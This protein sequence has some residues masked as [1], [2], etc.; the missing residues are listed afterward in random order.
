MLPNE[1]GRSLGWR[2]LAWETRTT[3]KFSDISITSTN[4]KEFF[5][6]L[7]L[8]SL[9]GEIHAH[10]TTIIAIFMLSIG[11]VSAD[12]KKKLWMKRAEDHNFPT[13]EFI[14]HEYVDGKY[15]ERNSRGEMGSWVDTHVTCQYT[16]FNY[17]LPSQAFNGDEDQ[18]ISMN[19]IIV[20]CRKNVL[21]L[22]HTGKNMQKMQFANN[23]LAG[24]NHSA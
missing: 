8:L 9:F 6:L 24:L 4:W 15:L 2:C 23:S 14:T 18:I 3:W 20:L 16:I 7:L 17:L 1:F 10:G 13:S 21:G 12:C 11:P 5:L 22:T 19:I